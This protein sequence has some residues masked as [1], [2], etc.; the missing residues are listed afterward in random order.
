MWVLATIKHTAYEEI[1][2]SR[3]R[4]RATERDWVGKT[5]V[6]AVRNQRCRLC[7]CV[8]VCVKGCNLMIN[9]ISKKRPL[10][11][12]FLSYRSIQFNL[13]IAKINSAVCMEIEI[14][15]C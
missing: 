15:Q 14:Q 10:Q 5:S 11:V 13:N 9:A 12:V 8:R 6:C 1:Q 3:L 2:Q 7:V 4:E